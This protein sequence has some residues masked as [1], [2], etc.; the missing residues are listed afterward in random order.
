[1]FPDNA[2]VDILYNKLMGVDQRENQSW[3]ACKMHLSAFL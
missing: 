3:E 2:Q 1:M